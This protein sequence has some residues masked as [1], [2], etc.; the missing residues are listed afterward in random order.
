VGPYALEDAVSWPEVRDARHG[1][2]LWERVRPMDSALTAFAPVQCDGAQARAFSHGQTITV[3]GAPAGRVRVYG[4][5]GTLLGIAVAR[6]VLVKPE[7]LLH[8]DPPRP[9]VLPA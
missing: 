9:S 6:G 3:P 1:A 8:A 2:A 7:R 5:D 4:A